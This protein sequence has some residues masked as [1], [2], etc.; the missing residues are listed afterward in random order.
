MIIIKLFSLFRGALQGGR[1]GAW[2]PRSG[3]YNEE[4]A[5]WQQNVDTWEGSQSGSE[6]SS[7]AS[8]GSEDL[9]DLL[10]S[11]NGSVSSGRGP[12]MGRNVS[13]GAWTRQLVL[14]DSLWYIDDDAENKPVWPTWAV[15]VLS[16]VRDVGLYN[17]G[18]PS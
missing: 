2:D 1:E 18:C 14:L 6:L 11:S 17:R 8:E 4:A 10:Q 5:T 3:G 12:P 7:F 16:G 13:T 15:G 9:I